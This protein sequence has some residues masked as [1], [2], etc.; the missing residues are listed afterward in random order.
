[1]KI[2]SKDIDIESL[3]K[4]QTFF[5]PRF[6]RPYS[7]DDENIQDLWNDVIASNG[8]D[9][10]IGS[11]VVFKQN[12]QAYGVV[13]GQQ[14][15]T[16]LTI[17]ICCIRDA[18]HALGEEDLALGLHQFVER[19]NSSYKDEYVL[20]T[21]TSFPYFQ[22]NIQ[23]LGTPDMETQ[24]LPEEK[25]HKRAHA[26]LT[27]KI[28]SII[29]AIETDASIPPAN[30]HGK[31]VSKL[32]ALRDSV[33]NLKIIFVTLENEDD[34]YL[35]FETLNT[36]GKDLS[37][38][39]LAKNH[40][41]KNLKKKSDVDSTRLLWD[42][43]LDTV[44]NT[45][46]DISTDDFFYHFWASRYES[47]PLK[48]LFPA[49]KKAVTAANAKS[50]LDEMVNDVTLYRAIHEPK[51]LWKNNEKSIA[52]SL[53]ALQLFKLSQPTPA[54]LSLV[55]SYKEGTIKP[56]TLLRA[57]SAIENFHF[58]FTAVTSSRSSGGISGMYSSF[59]KKLHCASDSNSA[60]IEISSL[61]EKLKD[62][63]PD[64]D[65]FKLGFRQ[66]GFTNDSPK[67][68]RLVQYILRKFVVHHKY[69]TVGDLDS[70]TIEHLVPQSEIGSNNWTEEIVG[71]LGNLLLLD[72]KFNSDIGNC[73]FEEKI[74]KIEASGYTIPE[75]VKSN[76]H[77]LPSG[78]AAHTDVMAET[79][80]NC[81][82]R[83]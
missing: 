69:L 28:D 10:F 47:V 24:E 52:D 26:T 57:L 34:A 50:K 21:E 1:L 12:K 19:K 2:E 68:K 38:T 73:S 55:R 54:V 11:M 16:T 83:I 29:N 79:A 65:E 60:G 20:K 62:R 40:F 71:Q 5:I 17:F 13:D 4:G 61:I 58:A 37:V 51:Y 42:K 25:T 43:I 18:L 74:R 64:L 80:Y 75:Y 27:S 48:K 23:K 32:E 39:D 15:L 9:Y 3:L 33:F 56:H 7:W 6:Q 8:A 59:A 14:R 63:R 36:R 44:H 45:A 66:I 46:A 35:I 49:M 70:L 41:S 72:G 22:E 81:I 31:K 78:V 67:Q 82:W 53:Q 77:W 76:S 30:K